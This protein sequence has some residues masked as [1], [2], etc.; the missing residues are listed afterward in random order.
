MLLH[1]GSGKTFFFSSDYVF[2][3]VNNGK[4]EVTEN[5]LLTLLPAS[6]SALFLQLL[7]WKAVNGRYTLPDWQ[8]KQMAQP[9]ET[10]CP[11][12]YQKLMEDF[13]VLHKVDTVCFLSRTPNLV[14]LTVSCQ[15]PHLLSSFIDYFI[16]SPN[17]S[18]VII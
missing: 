11:Y 7:H 8:G 9:T 15:I 6:A 13:A 1:V 18:G 16:R 2:F 5:H 10:T 3:H 4:R 17:D 14:I 12:C